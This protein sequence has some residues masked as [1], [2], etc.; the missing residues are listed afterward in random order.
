MK[1]RIRWDVTMKTEAIPRRP[2]S[3]A[4]SYGTWE[5]RRTMEWR[6]GRKAKERIR[7]GKENIGEEGSGEYIGP[8]DFS[9]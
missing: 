1:A 7:R 6:K 8:F 3:C 4:I 2:W 9:S 5:E